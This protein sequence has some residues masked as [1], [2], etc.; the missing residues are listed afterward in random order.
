MKKSYRILSSVLC[1]GL[2]LGGCGAGSGASTKKNN[3]DSVFFLSDPSARDFA[4][5]FGTSAVQSLTYSQNHET[6]FTCTLAGDDPQ[7]QS[8]F[9]ALC[10]VT[11]GSTTTQMASDYDD[12]FVFTTTDGQTCTLTFN[13][14][15][16]VTDDTIYT[17]NNDKALWQLADALTE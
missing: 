5:T 7:L 14:H 9:D 17:L 16:L 13:Q 11:I 6:S 8:I 15:H 10:A 3:T 4:A 1:L 2:F 12:I